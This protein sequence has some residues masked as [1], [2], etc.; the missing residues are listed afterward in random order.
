[1]K[2][3]IPK[4]KS[5]IQYEDDDF[6]VINKP[7]FISSLEDRHENINMLK[8]SRSYF[9]GAQL[10]HRLDKETSGVL[11]IAKNQEAYRFMSQQFEKRKIEKEYH[12][13]TEG[14][15]DFKNLR[16]DKP[17]SISSNGLARIEARFGKKSITV[18]TAVKA[19][20]S[21]TLVKCIPITGRMHQI[22]AH[23]AYLNAP[24]VGDLNY[25]GKPFLLSSVKRN[26]KLG[27]YEEE[28][29]LIRRLALHAYR[30]KFKVI[31][32]EYKEVIAPY[33]KDFRVLL[34]QLRKNA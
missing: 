15:H 3:R 18:F 28:L 6:I 17:L 33:P 4:F 29:P 13:V 23:L 34:D 7:A 21:H 30:I 8:L 1:M 5:M 19:F 24:I 12:A 22:R 9:D 27:K 10:C 2:Q 20:R 26:Y 25:G 14:L 16:L 11:I 32:G 31:N